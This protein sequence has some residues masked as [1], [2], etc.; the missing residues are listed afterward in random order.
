MVRPAPP[1]PSPHPAVPYSAGA[2]LF[3]WLTLLVMIGSFALAFVMVDLPIGPL[4]VDLYNW[5]KTLGL[6]ILALAVLRLAWR[7]THPAPPLPAALPT[8]ER[9]AAGATHVALYVLLFGQPLIGLV[10]AWVSGFPTLLFGVLALPSPLAA[11]QALYD[12]LARLHGLSAW[13]LLALIALHAGA[14][15]RHHFVKRDEVLRRMLPGRPR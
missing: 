2:K 1:T 10:M 13:L 12:A 6:A 9:R 5:H 11:D 14:A 4:K 7:L 15:L 3:H 8:W